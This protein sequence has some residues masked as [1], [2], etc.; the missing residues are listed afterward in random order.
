MGDDRV[1]TAYERAM[2]KISKLGDLSPEERLEMKYKPIGERIAAG[3]MR[4][5]A[6][7][8]AEMEKIVP[9]GRPYAIAAAQEILL[10]NIA[11]PSN[12]VKEGIDEWVLKGIVE[13]KSDTRGA[14][15]VI[16]QI[17]QL[18]EH[19]KTQGDAQRKEAYER[20]KFQ[21]QARLR[22][23]M[24]AQGGEMPD[25][26]SGDVEALPQFQDQWR[27]MQVQLDSQYDYWLQ[28][29]KDALAAVL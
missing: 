20:L 14:R 19:Y 25:V 27:Q 7:L 22:Q 5:D 17:N 16:D 1:K 6:S 18:F 24:Q 13:L 28:E 3:Y 21:F 9:E 11:L 12:P 10:S 15:V 29:Y 2:E 8:P 26:M 23:A 4:R